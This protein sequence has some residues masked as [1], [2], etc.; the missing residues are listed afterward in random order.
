MFD[1]DSLGL[2]NG[3]GY[4]GEEVSLT[5]V[6]FFNFPSERVRNLCSIHTYRLICIKL[7]F[8]KKV[9]KPAGF[10]APCELRFNHF[11]SLGLIKK[12]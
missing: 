11:I 3:F 12:R 5:P 9:D 7:G 6:D 8:E 1:G 10:S 2:L 4:D